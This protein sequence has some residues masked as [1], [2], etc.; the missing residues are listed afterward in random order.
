MKTIRAQFA[1]IFDSR[2]PKN[3]SVVWDILT[4]H[5]QVDET[6]PADYLFAST[7]TTVPFSYCGFDGVRIL[8]NGENFSPDF[9]LFDY[10]IGYDYLSY[11]DRYFRAPLWM[12]TLDAV[13][14]ETQHLD[15]WDAERVAAEKPRFCNF[16]YNHPGDGEQRVRM[17]ELLNAYKRVD[18]AGRYKNNMPEDWFASSYQK[19]MDFQRSCKFTIAFDSVALPGFVTEKLMH[20]FQSRTVPIYFGDPLVAKTFNPKAFVNVSDFPSL[21]AAV[22]RVKEIDSNIDM[23]LDMLNQPIFLEENYVTKQHQALE[24][25]L[26]NIFDQ[27]KEAAYRRSRTHAAKRHNDRLLASSKRLARQ[28]KDTFLRRSWRFTK[29]EYQKGGLGQV[30]RKIGAKVRYNVDIIIHGR[31]NKRKSKTM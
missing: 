25:F 20:A 2:H 17:M 14:M 10:C 27:E 8:Y 16:I 3:N 31:S 19:K 7:L 23:Y 22:E 6:V 11:G 5:Y 21:E 29:A 30:F 1:N 13:S 9:N 15:R 26:T 28:E 18:N 12:L 24:V 4:R